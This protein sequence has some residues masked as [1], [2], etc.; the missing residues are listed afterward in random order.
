MFGP[1]S[2]VALARI[3]SSGRTASS[4]PAGLVFSTTF[5]TAF[6]TNFSG[7]FSAFFSATGAFTSAGVSAFGVATSSGAFS[8]F[9][10][11][12][13]SS[14]GATFFAGFSTGVST[15]TLDAST[16]ASTT[17]SFAFS[18]FAFL[19]DFPL[20]ETVDK[21]IFPRILKLGEE[22]SSFSTTFSFSGALTIGLASTTSGVTDR[23]LIR[24][25]ST[26]SDS[27]LLFG[28]GSASVG[29]TSSLRSFPMAMLFASSRIVLSDWKSFIKIPYCSS[30]NL[31]PGLL[32]MFTPSFPRCSTM[33]PMLTLNSFAAFNKLIFLSSD[34][35]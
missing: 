3:T 16:F 34:I 22:L 25:S 29:T 12:A 32:S 14:T 6:S 4:A 5:S 2:F 35:Y 31:V 8:T 11:T 19:S 28:A 23:F 26:T 1:V 20:P 33:V 24:I 21:S 15:T 30:L 27:A 13:G 9:F 7:A 17:S 18:S 10:L